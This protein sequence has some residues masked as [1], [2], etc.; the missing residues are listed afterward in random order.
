MH[1]ETRLHSTGV[2]LVET[3]IIA[4]WSVWA[5]LPTWGTETGMSARVRMAGSTQGGEYTCSGILVETQVS[6]G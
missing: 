4:T 5:I 3:T 1:G 2:S 6:A